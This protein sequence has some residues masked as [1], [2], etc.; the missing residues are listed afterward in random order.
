MRLCKLLHSEVCDLYSHTHTHILPTAQ[1]TAV[2][3]SQLYRVS[4]VATASVYWIVFHCCHD[5]GGNRS[6]SSY[7][8]DCWLLVFH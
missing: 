7:T 2:L 4:V 1:A 5:N 8:R 6:L 3:V